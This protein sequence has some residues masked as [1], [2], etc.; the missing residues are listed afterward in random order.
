MNSTG[1][2]TGKTSSTIIGINQEYDPRVKT[3]LR[4]KEHFI[5]DI[6][7]KE[8]TYVTNT[9]S[10]ESIKIKILFEGINNIMNNS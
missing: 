5:L 7:K 6:D 4:I 10:P 3:T 9:N 8:F 1:S 2:F